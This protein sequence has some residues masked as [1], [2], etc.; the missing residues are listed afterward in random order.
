MALPSAVVLWGA[1]GFVGRN[2]AAALV[3]RGVEVAAVSRGGAAV[4]GCRAVAA[5]EAEA[6][7]ALPADAVVVNLAAHRYDASRFQTGQ[8]EILLHNTA[9]AAA[10]YHFCAARGL[11][12]LRQAS[13]VAVYPAGAAV[14][15][16][17]APLDLGAMPHG[18]EAFY[19]WSKRFAEVAAD[20]YRDRYGVSTVSFRLSNPY[21]PHDSTDIDHAHVVPAFIL[22]AL[23]PQPDFPVRGDPRAERDFVYVGDV[24]EVLLRSLER[25][26]E[27]GA[28]NL[29]S[30]TTTSIA[31]LARAVLDACGA[32]KPIV[33]GGA[34]TSAVQVRRSPSDRLRAAYGIDR[35]TP[36][37]EGLA[38]TVPWYRDALAQ[39]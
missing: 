32:D 14:L 31:D 7:P 34:A 1:T 30:G 38:R 11:T 10:V 39:R 33:A 2:L 4:P 3:A 16:D 37:A 24:V 20:L 9:L 35:F 21:G 12:E 18:G 13:S 28:Y 29:A 23:G 6:M 25:R 36:L 22:K 5:A 19:G 17:S 27:H 15:D 8:S 26:G